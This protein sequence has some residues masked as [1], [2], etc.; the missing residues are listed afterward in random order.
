MPIGLYSKRSHD[1]HVTLL[2]GMVLV[3]S[4]Y[5]YFNVCDIFWKVHVYMYV[6]MYVCV[7]CNN[8]NIIMILYMLF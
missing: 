5:N 4:W 7:K 8:N 3:S 1:N 2:A 6:C